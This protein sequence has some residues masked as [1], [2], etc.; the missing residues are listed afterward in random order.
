MADI[1]AFVGGLPDQHAVVAIL[2]DDDRDEGVGAEQGGIVAGGDLEALGI[3]DGDVGVE[4]GAAE[5]HAF[6]LGA[7]T[8]AL[9]QTTNVVVGVLGLGD[10]L[11]GG[12]EFDPLRLFRGVVGVH[13]VHGRKLADEERAEVADSATRADPELVFAERGVGLDEDLR[14]GVFA[15]LDRDTADLDA[16]LVGKQLLQ[17]V[18][19]FAV[20]VHLQLGPALAAAGLDEIE[21]RGEAGVGGWRGKRPE[22]RDQSEVGNSLGESNWRQGARRSLKGLARDAPATILKKVHAFFARRASSTW[23]PSTISMGRPPGAISSLSPV[24]PIWL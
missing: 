15:I 6:D 13:L 5:P 7:E 21:L 20:E 23:P 8:L 2:R 1:G 17:A 18:E 9:F 24:I 19:S 22:T 10:A 14:G 12:V 3:D 11:D 16:G 4:H